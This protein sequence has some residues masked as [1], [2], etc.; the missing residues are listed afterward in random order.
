MH[1]DLAKDIAFSTKDKTP[2]DVVRGLARMLKTKIEI[3]PDIR[4]EF[5]GQ[6]K[7]PEEMQGVSAGT[8][9]T[10]DHSA[11]WSCRR[12]PSTSRRGDN[13]PNLRFQKRQRVLADWLA[14]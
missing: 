12:S 9:L 5:E 4:N 14:D 1:N 10:G 3:A 6:W 7:V 13:A 11:A 8:V 2:K